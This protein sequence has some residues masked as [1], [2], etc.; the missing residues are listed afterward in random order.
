MTIFNVNE[1]K[2]ASASTVTYTLKCAVAACERTVT[3]SDSTIR[4]IV[5]ESNPNYVFVQG[6]VYC[7]NH[8]A[9][10]EVEGEAL[11]GSEANNG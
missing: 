11:D 6:K 5:Y 9:L 3:L 8:R 1:Y 10:G 7:R 2:K 4:D